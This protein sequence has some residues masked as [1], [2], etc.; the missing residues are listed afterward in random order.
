MSHEGPATCKQ[1]EEYLLSKLAKDHSG[2]KFKVLRIIRYLCE[3]DCSPEFRRLVQKKADAIRQCQSFRGVQDPLRGDSANKDV[4]EEAAATMKSLFAAENSS[5]SLGPGCNPMQSRIQSMGSSDYGPMTAP[6]RPQST[7]N[8]GPAPYSSSG[9]R[10]MESMGNPY[11]N[12]YATP[13]SGNSFSSIMQSD[14][15]T[16]ELISAVTSGVQSVVETLAQKANPY[17]PSHMQ[18]HPQPASASYSSS[19]GPSFQTS[20]PAPARSDWAPPRMSPPALVANF[21][22]S[23]MTASSNDET[24]KSLVNELC[25]MNAARVAPTQQSLDLFV[26]KCETVDGVALGQALVSKLSD[27]SVQWV[28]KMK[29]LAGVEAIH[30]SGL[31]AVTASFIDNPT[32]LMNLFSS[33]QCGTKARQ[34]AQQLGLIDGVVFVKKPA[35]GGSGRS[36]PVVDDL[37][38][39]GDTGSSKKA[40]AAHDEAQTISK[41]GTQPKEELIDLT[42]GKTDD[43]LN[44]SEPSSLI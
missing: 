20:N 33:P 44:F 34:V 8:S 40:S 10:Q 41:S 18:S 2:V 14:N 29:V 30:A 32:G 1:L 22:N 7:F 23:Y 6:P 3:N 43:L 37:L 4:R 26:S 12:N 5:S 15:R 24:A 11:F 38:D 42:S 39:L 16:R 21:D 28:H 31:D 19:L 9:P 36:S 17:L 35:T 13:S 25:A 27:P